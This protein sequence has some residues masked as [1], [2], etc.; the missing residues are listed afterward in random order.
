MT[1]QLRR[2]PHQLRVGR[3]RVRR[4]MAEMGLLQ[5]TRRRRSTTNSQHGLGI[6]PNLVKGVKGAATGA[7]LGRRHHAHRL[8]GQNRLI[9]PSS[10][11]STRAGYAAGA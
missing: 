6:Y 2:A 5:K 9:W 1:A 11:M 3:H 8:A 4:L 10:W 7:Y